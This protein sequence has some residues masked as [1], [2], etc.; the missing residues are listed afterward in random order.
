MKRNSKV[1]K[2]NKA[3]TTAEV[4]PIRPDASM[5]ILAHGV[6]PETVIGPVLTKAQ[7]IAKMHEFQKGRSTLSEVAEL[8][9]Q[10]RLD[11]S[12]ITKVL[13]EEAATM[14]LTK[15]GKVP[16]FTSTPTYKSLKVYVSRY[17]K[18]HETPAAQAWTLSVAEGVLSYKQ[19]QDNRAAK[20]PKSLDDKIHDLL[21]EA[22]A[23]LNDVQCRARVTGIMEAFLAK[24]AI[25]KAATPAQAVPVAKAA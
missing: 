16:S 25:A 13:E 5:A 3:R 8:T 11:V 2:G 1:Q 4:L 23:Q 14:P 20:V 10:R 7:T 21:N 19:Q 9:A 22:C 6:V 18:V 17:H 24:L 12:G 15:D